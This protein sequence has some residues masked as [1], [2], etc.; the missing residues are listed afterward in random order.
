MSWRLLTG[1]QLCRLR[2]F[3]KPQPALKIRPSSVCVTYGT[4]CQSN[5]ENKRTVETLRACSVDIG[6][7][8]RLKGWVLLEEETYAEE[9]ANILKELGA[10]QTVIASIL[11]R[12]PEAIVCSPAAVNTKRKLWQM[13]CKTKTELIQLIEQFP[14]SFFAVKDQENQKLNVQFF[15]ELGLKNVV[16]TRFLTTASSIFHNPVENNKQMIGV[17][18]ESYLNLGGSEANAK[19]WLLKL[20]SQN[21][22]IVLSSPTAVG[23]VL[24]FL[25]GQGFTDSEVLQLLSKLKGFLFQLQPGSIQ[26]SISFTKTTFECTDHDLRQLVV[27]CPAL[28]YYPAPVLEERIQALLK[29]GISVAQIRASPMVLELTPQ[30]IQYRIRKLNSLGYGIKDGHLASLNGTKKEFEANFSKMQAKQG[31]PLFNPVA[32]LKVEE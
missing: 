4:D 27:K 8:C 29:E 2:L 20:L 3:R 11:E 26:N 15:Q 13:V 12:C 23:E 18:L 7:I 1:Y 16:I 25:Q 5:K 30:I 32:S 31:R 6:K 21:P 10:N 22:F 17:L 19:V 24:K 9:I 14:E 28:L